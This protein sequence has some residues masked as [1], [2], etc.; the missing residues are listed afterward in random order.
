MNNKPL[1]ARMLAS[2]EVVLIS[3]D[4]SNY[5]YWIV[6]NAQLVIDTGNATAKVKGKRRKIVKA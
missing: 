3:T 4:H 6:R 5:Y 1:S 2:Y